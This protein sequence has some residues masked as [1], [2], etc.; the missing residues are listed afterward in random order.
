MAITRKPRK[1]AVSV[2]ALINK[3]G[4][5]AQLSDKP[6]NGSAEKQV[7]LRVPAALLVRLDESLK[8]RLIRIPR[9]TWIL[10]AI[11]EKL[12]HETADK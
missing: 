10:E 6:D 9:H 5:V 11:S 7:V 3:G 8:Q 2:D 4:S 12:E 1:Q